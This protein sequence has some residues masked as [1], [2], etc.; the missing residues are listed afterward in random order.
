MSVCHAQQIYE[1]E[2][3]SKDNSLF[4]VN[5]ENNSNMFFVVNND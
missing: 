1:G 5:K 3:M 4:V 2:L